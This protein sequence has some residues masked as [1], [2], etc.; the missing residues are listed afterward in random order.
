MRFNVQQNPFLLAF[1]LLVSF[2]AF[3]P[4]VAADEIQ[5]EEAIDVAT[6]ESVKQPV[7]PEAVETEGDDVVRALSHNVSIAIG[8]EVLS[9][10]R[11]R[12]SPG[13]TIVWVNNSQYS[14]RVEFTGELVSTTCKAP[15]GFVVGSSGA[16]QSEFIAAQSVASLCF[17]E[18]G[19]Y[20]YAIEFYNEGA[21]KPELRSTKKGSIQVSA[22]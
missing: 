22:T 20:E 18:P 1:L 19:Q 4:H 11:L 8:D 14:I 15:R 17:L 6:G 13:T 10:E 9:P 7:D 2:T 16:F 5:T 21:P 3:L 12:I